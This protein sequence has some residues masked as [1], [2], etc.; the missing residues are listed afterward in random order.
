GGGGY[1]SYTPTE[2][3]DVD[4]NVRAIKFIGDGSL[5]T[6]LPAGGGTITGVT[7]GSGLSGGGTS[8]DVNLGVDFATTQK[9]VSGI[10]AG[11][12]AIQTVNGDGTVACVPVGGG[13]IGGS[14]ATNHLAR[15]DNGQLSNSLVTDDGSSLRV[16]VPGPDGLIGQV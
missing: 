5:L 13:G 9:R 2:A 14:G 10:C 6:N 11:G 15:W 12:S 8:G 16:A 4:G 3:L 1:F 7:P